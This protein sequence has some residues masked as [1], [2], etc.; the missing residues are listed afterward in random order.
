MAQAVSKADEVVDPACSGARFFVGTR[1]QLWGDTALMVMAILASAFLSRALHYRLQASAAGVFLGVAAALIGWLF[2]RQL[3]RGERGWMFYAAMLL[4]GALPSRGDMAVEAG[5]APAWA[6]AVALLTAA[7]A[8]V[9]IVGAVRTVRALDEMWRQ[10]NYRALAFAFIATLVAVL[11][12]WLLEPLGFVFL[13][14][15]RLPLLMAVLWGVGMI[16]AY[17]RLR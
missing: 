4:F 3:V 1:R 11:A 8:V 9:G 12:Q 15:W 14:W 5:A 7:P 17:R 6:V 16:W 13:T 10:I 2:V